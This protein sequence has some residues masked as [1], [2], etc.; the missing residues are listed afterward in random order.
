MANVLIAG[1][2][3]SLG[4]A[5]AEHLTKSGHE[6]YIFTR[7]VNL[8]IPYTQILWDG[9]S[10]GINAKDIFRNSIL[11][12]LAGE[13][14]DRIPT[15]KNVGLL[16]SSRVE[17]TRALAGAAKEFGLPKLWLQM[18]TLAIYG[19][20]GD[21]ML[22]EESQVADGPVQMA[23]VARAWEAEVN[24]DIANRVVIL[25]TAVVLQPDTPALNRLTL[26][27]KMFLGGQ[28][29]NGKQWFSWI[30]YKDFLDAITFLIESKLEG[31]THITSPEP[32][33]NRDLMSL[34]RKALKRGYAP[35]T[36]VIAIK[37]GAYALFRTDPQLALTGR[38][39]VP[40]KL[41]EAGFRFKHPELSEALNDL[42][43]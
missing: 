3:G 14:V 24:P 12:N 29:G 7:K 6:V 9:K 1:G 10:V 22:T 25:R 33:T 32:R 17:P 31:I 39:A 11:I 34:L 38:R 35:P 36:P 4:L 19:D 40:K 30:H 20:A 2:S 26:M 16:R 27:T 43:S 37:I 15:K 41:Q 5:I 8:D 18:S 21:Q 28:V 23:G 42:L 13:L